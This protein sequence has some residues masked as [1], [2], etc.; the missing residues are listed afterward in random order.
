MLR[1]AG[2]VGFHAT[3]VTVGMSHLLWVLGLKP[4][5]YLLGVH[6]ALLIAQLSLQ[7]FLFGFEIGSHYVEA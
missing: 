2:G 7:P 3:R 6:C 1:E 5:N 4:E